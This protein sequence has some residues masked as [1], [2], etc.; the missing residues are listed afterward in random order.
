MAAKR[1]SWRIKL[2]IALVAFA[3][4]PAVIVAALA[5]Q[6]FSETNR[7]SR[8]QSMEGL[9]KAK[10]AAIDEFTDTRRKDVERM[11]DL[12][13]PPFATLLATRA[14]AD[15]AGHEVVAEPEVLPP[16]ADAGQTPAEEET[17]PEALVPS[18]DTDLPAPLDPDKVPPPKKDTP[19]VSG[20]PVDPLTANVE[21]AH[22]DLTKALGLLVGDRGVF[23]EL[24][25][26]DLEGRVVASTYREHERRDASN[27][28]YSQRGRA[29][30][31]VEPV[32]LSPLTNRLTMVIATPVRDADSRDIGVLAARLDLE[33]LYK[34]VSDRVGLG[35]TGETV[36]TRRD[37]EDFVFMAPTRHDKTAV[38]RRIEA[39]SAFATTL[40][41]EA[42]DPEPGSGEGTDYRDVAVLAGWAPVPTLGWGVIAKIDR[43][44]VTAQLRAV[45]LQ[46][47]LFTVLVVAAAVGVALLMARTMVRPLRSLQDAAERISRGDFNVNINVRTNDE[48]EDLADSFE[49]MVAAIKYFR[50]PPPP[51]DET[52]SDEDPG[53]PP[54]PADS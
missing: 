36:V 43:E 9:A 48:V 16:L 54:P 11:A 38:D 46:T 14:T 53:E 6:S 23:E 25:V 50:E 10:A 5:L 22:A 49:R 39:S 13:G 44:E 3:T 24:L 30:T 31:Y 47:A 42:H 28:V 4:L 1:R 34:L 26:M 8:L 33:R 21:G 45:R 27:L 12:L 20:T 35:E 41:R 37:G 17:P 51:E 32:F 15:A 40:V 52:V 7:A 29:A 19:P 18:A 2:I